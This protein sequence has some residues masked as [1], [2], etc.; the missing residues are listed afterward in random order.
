MTEENPTSATDGL[1][2]VENDDGTFTLEWDENDP[3]YSIF[4]GLSEEQ[5]QAMIQYGLQEIINRE[6]IYD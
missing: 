3:R 6:E 1:N 4:N 5:I 2:V